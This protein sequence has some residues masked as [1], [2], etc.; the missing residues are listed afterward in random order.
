MKNDRAKYKIIDMS[1]ASI[2][3]ISGKL[4][5]ADLLN[6]IDKRK[7][8]PFS[9]SFEKLYF[10]YDFSFMEISQ[11]IFSNNQK[12]NDIFANLSSLE[13]KILLRELSTNEIVSSSKDR[14]IPL[15]HKKVFENWIFDNAKRNSSLLDGYRLLV[16]EQLKCPKTITDLQHLYNIFIKPRNAELHFKNIKKY[17]YFR[18]EKISLKESSNLILDY[19]GDLDEQTIIVNVTQYLKFLNDSTFDPYSKI[20]VFFFLFMKSMPYYNENYFLA[21]LIM[22]LYLFNS[23]KSKILSLF[24]SKIFEPYKQKLILYFNETL[25]VENHGD[26]GHF[27]YK[28]MEIILDGTNK[29]LQKLAILDAKKKDLIAKKDKKE[30]KSFKAIK[31]VFIS[32]SI[33]TTYGASIYEVEEETKISV[34]TINRFIKDHSEELTKTRFIKR[35]YY[36][37]K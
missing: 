20:S 25:S 36:K 21:K 9:V 22:S 16:T 37:Y 35:D 14:F 18:T 12:I 24:L 23:E 29:I 3:N 30:S 27:A 7:S 13:Q 32:S 26:I 31:E 19:V 8:N 33:Y 6:E 4:V 17:H 2:Y 34:P 1:Y 11:K 10:S 15:Q 5:E 28:V